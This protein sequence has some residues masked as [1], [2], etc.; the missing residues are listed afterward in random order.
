MPLNS[1]DVIVAVE[2]GGAVDQIVSECS[3]ELVAL[4][5]LFHRSLETDGCL[6]NFSS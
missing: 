1:V 5:A 6:G 3:C 2:S 4:F